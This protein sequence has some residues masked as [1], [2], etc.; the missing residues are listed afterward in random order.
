MH[1]FIKEMNLMQNDQAFKELE[2]TRNIKILIASVNDTIIDYSKGLLKSFDIFVEFVKNGNELVNNMNSE[3]EYD[4]VFMDIYLPVIDGLAS[5]K[6]IRNKNKHTP[7]IALTEKSISY[8]KVLCKKA[9]INDF[10]TT[11]YKPK[12][13]FKLLLHWTKRNRLNQSYINF[14]HIFSIFGNNYNTYTGIVNDFFNRY[15]DIKISIMDK[16][17]IHKLKG[18]SGTLGLTR[19]MKLSIKIHNDND[20]ILKKELI[21]EFINTQKIINDVF[22]TYITNISDDNII[23][24]IKTLLDDS[25]TKSISYFYDNREAFKIELKDQFDAVESLIL[26]YNFIEV[27]DILSRD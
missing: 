16:D 2:E 11:P 25:D 22:K 27:L 20:I 7:V 17:Y 26:N 24:T 1:N 19:I 3:N 18:A 8:D 12:E 13:F 14:K 9:G 21:E 5:I 6:I 23:K 10:L 15:K 4:L